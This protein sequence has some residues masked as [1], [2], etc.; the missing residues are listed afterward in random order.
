MELT[1]NSIKFIARVVCGECRYAPYKSSSELVEFFNQFG[2]EDK[3]GKGF[4]SRWVYSENKLKKLNG[5]AKLKEVIE[6]TLEPDN[7]NNKDFNIEIIV[8]Q[9]NDFLIP[10][11]YEIKKDQ[12]A[13]KISHKDSLPGLKDKVKNI[14]F[15]AIG[16][17][18]EIAVSDTGNIEIAGSEENCLT[19]NFAI[20]VD[21]G[22]PWL[23][24]VDWWADKN[25]PVNTIEKNQNDLYLRLYKS[26]ETDAGKILFKTYYKKFKYLGDRLPALLPRVYFHNVPGMINELNRGKKLENYRIDFLMILPEHKNV[27]IQ[28]DS[29]QHY[30]DYDKFSPKKYAE[31]LSAERK[32]KLNNY[33]VFRFSAF[34]FNSKN[35]ENAIEDFFTKLFEKYSVIKK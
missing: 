9:I 7:F 1:E 15:A 16:P 8:N 23:S 6:K 22:L 24:L 14:V 29:K 19:Y 13:Y 35:E 31:I 18:P 12:F 33:E 20:P 25:P 17:K 5:S 11:G 32:L 26:I 34:E 3:Y 28:V 4:P 30:A 2:F 21:K 10:D 27:V